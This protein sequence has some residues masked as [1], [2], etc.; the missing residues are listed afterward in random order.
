MGKKAVRLLLHTVLII[1]TLA[2]VLATGAAMLAAMVNPN[3]NGFVA[4]MGL[5]LPLLLIAD[6]MFVFYWIFR[7]RWWFFFP[8]L[9]LVANYQ[10]YPRIFRLDDKTA[11]TASQGDR[12]LRVATYNINYFSYDDYSRAVGFVATFLK[13]ENIDVVCF[14]EFMN[15]P[16]YPPDSVAA[17]LGLPYFALG[18]NSEDFDDLAVF[19]RYPIENTHLLV[20]KNSTNSAMW[21]DVDVEGYKLRLFNG[22]LQTTS[23]NWEKDDLERQIALGT[24]EDQARAA[25]RISNIMKRNFTRRAFQVDNIVAAIDTCSLPV[26]YCG[27]CNDTPSSYA[28]A[29]L[30]G[31]TSFR[32]P[33]ERTDG[34]LEAG[35]GYAYT[36][37]AMKKILRIDYII[38]S[39]SIKGVD[40]YSPLLNWSD[41]NPVLMTLKLN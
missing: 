25:I 21:T 7:R 23:V 34:F 10:Y 36:Y 35:K 11:A 33:A 5:G 4:L 8:L 1:F 2:T 27:D 37:Q 3:D 41:H 22:H 15:N 6:L 13:N 9:A 12:L 26:V 20:F 28:Y 14:Q 16:A 18:H 19:S 17:A 30:T 38:Y 29:Q 40:Y 39:S 31:K 32:E 24:T